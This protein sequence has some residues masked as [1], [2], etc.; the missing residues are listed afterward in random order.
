MGDL[1]LKSVAQ[2]LKGCLRNSDTVARLGGDEFVVILTGIPGAQ[3]SRVAQKLLDTLAQPF[4]I[5][6]KK[7]TVTTSVGISLY[8]DDGKGIDAQQ[9]REKIV[10]KRLISA[11]DAQ[12]LTES[13]VI[14]YIFEPGFSNA[15][16]VTEISGRG[17]GMD[18]VK[19][20]VESIG[21]QV[22]VTTKVLEGTTISLTLPSSLALKGSLLFMLGEQE[23]AVALSYTDAV[24]SVKKKDIHRLRPLLR[25]RH[26]YCLYLLLV[27]CR[28][29]GTCCFACRLRRPMSWI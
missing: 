19:K 6:S 4:V 3:V 24:V 1:L 28:W 26:S 16:K 23:Y 7:V 15:A 20:A 14:N 17:V 10:E 25:L 13:E 22:K 29:N 11:K 18:V 21:G 9:I 27:A 8:P 12:K 2:R 5:Q